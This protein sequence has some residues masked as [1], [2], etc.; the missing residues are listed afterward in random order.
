MAKGSGVLT[1][2]SLQFPQAFLA[3]LPQ[4]DTPGIQFE[5]EGRRIEGAIIVDVQIK[6]RLEHHRY[7][8]YSEYSIVN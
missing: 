2:T 1:T 6:D 3:C 4:T 5:H 8:D 7:G